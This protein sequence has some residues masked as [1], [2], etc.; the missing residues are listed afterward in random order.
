MPEKD[1]EKLLGGYAT[2]T[3]TEE[4]RKAL[5]EA[6]LHDQG[7]FNALADEQALKEL[8]DDPVSRRRLLDMLEKASAHPAAGWWT[9]VI[10][11]FRRPANLAFAGTLATAVIVIVVVVNIQRDG[12]YGPAEEF[13]TAA[14]RRAEQAKPQSQAELEVD[15]L[16]DDRT[17]PGRPPAVGA[18]RPPEPRAL[19]KAK[20]EEDAPASGTFDRFA[21][22]PESP[23][24]TLKSEAARAPSVMAVKP[25]EAPAQMRRL[26][27]S[28]GPVMER[29]PARELFYRVAQEG[30]SRGRVGLEEAAGGKV[31][32]ISRKP[33][34]APQK[35]TR[36]EIA[37][38]GGLGERG[39]PDAI[40]AVNPMGIRYSILKQGGDGIFRETNPDGPFSADD[41]LRLTVE[42]NEPGY[43]YVFQQ[44]PTGEWMSLMGAEVLRRRRYAIPSNGTLSLTGPPGGRKMVIVFSRGAERDFQ[45]LLSGATGRKDSG[46]ATSEYVNR[47]LNRAYEE[48]TTKPLL[49]QKMD[50]GQVGSPPEQA[51]YIVKRSPGPT[52]SLV[53]EF[54]LSTR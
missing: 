52:G 11:W 16:L 21:H 18:P 3:L 4:E 12:T 20:K 26:Q 1:L 51:V 29:G 24:P 23:Q 31:P 14:S 32:R 54:F 45:A 10:D 15:A 19:R 2:G 39:D 5:F 37:G 44:A 33:A 46:V 9:P 38:F 25:Q 53:A 34:E 49:V 6:A 7:L 22:P 47:L 30:S 43:L 42:A 27:A 28:L 35:E 13:V 8:L 17:A 40:T 50:A 41:V 36:N 48:A